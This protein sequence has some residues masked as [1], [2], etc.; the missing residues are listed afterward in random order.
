MSSRLE[1]CPSCSRHVRLLS[2]TCPF[3]GAAVAGVFRSRRA[4]RP[5]PP[6]LNRWELVNYRSIAAVAVGVTAA[7]CVTSA[8]ACSSSNTSSSESS[9]GTTSGSTSS[10]STGT[11]GGSVSPIAPGAKA[12]SFALPGD[13]PSSCG[14]M[15][16]VVSSGDGSACGGKEVY[17]LCDHG[18][19]TQ[20]DCGDP[21]AGWE[22]A[23]QATSTAEADYG[24]TI[25]T[26]FTSET[27]ETSSESSSESASESPSESASSSDASSQHSASIGADYGAP[28]FSSS[29]DESSGGSS[30]H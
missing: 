3:C 11:S 18:S 6:G 5:P 10:G 9:S 15:S 25:T 2:P 1:T 21:G 7:A 16:Y 13:V 29:T 14:G 26:S 8:A 4:P 27:S 22:T 23:T 28:P 30:G 17:F 12:V 19:F 24:V 20:Y